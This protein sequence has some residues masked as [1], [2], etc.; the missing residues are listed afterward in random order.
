[1]T[2]PLRDEIVG[3][4]G[5]LR[6]NTRPRS[7]TEREA[8][9]GDQH[10]MSLRTGQARWQWERP[11]HSGP[12]SQGRGRTRTAS[13]EDS[14]AGR[15]MGPWGEEQQ[16]GAGCGHGSV[17]GLTSPGSQGAM[18]LLTPTSSV[19]SGQGVTC[20]QVCRGTCSP[21]VAVSLLT[22]SSPCCPHGPTVP[23]GALGPALLSLG[24]PIPWVPAPPAAF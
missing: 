24:Y 20:A 15:E 7:E 11:P 5:V 4:L 14:I 22:P 3:E 13:C 6:G 19:S 23:P 21:S 9:L 10:Q 12:R 16:E 17:P 18:R 2:L 1:M 8:V